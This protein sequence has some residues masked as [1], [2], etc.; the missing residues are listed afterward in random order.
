MTTV[1]IEQLKANADEAKK[2]YETEAAKTLPNWILD[3]EPTR[4]DAQQDEDVTDE[5]FAK[6]KDDELYIAIFSANSLDY[7]RYTH[8]ISIE[9]WKK[10]HDR[11]GG[12]VP[13]M[14]TKDADKYAEM[15]VPLPSAFKQFIDS[16][17]RAAV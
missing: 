8:Q 10:T 4:A 5:E 13:W 17:D 3:R 9:N 11:V 15:E 12:P 2:L 16:Q 1:S 7:C 14:T 6:L